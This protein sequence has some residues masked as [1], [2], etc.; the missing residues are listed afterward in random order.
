MALTQSVQAQK[1]KSSQ[2]FLKADTESTS[3]LT[4]SAGRWEPPWEDTHHHP[5]SRLQCGITEQVGANTDKYEDCPANCPYFAQNRKDTQHCT[6]L[7][8]PGAE[9]GRWNPNKPIP[10]SIKNTK[11]CRGPKVSFCKTPTLDGKD[12]CKVCMSGYRLH[13]DDGQCYFT[14]WT[15]I[16][17]VG[18]VFLVIFVLVTVWV[19]D[20]CC[21]R[22][23]INQESVTKAEAWRSRSKII[24]VDGGRRRTFATM[25]TNLCTKD[26]AGP[27]MLLH[28]NFQLFF[29]IWPLCCALVWVAL[30]CVHNELFIL[31]TR[32][33]G[34]PRHN[35]ILVAWGYETQQRLMWTKVLFLAVVYI[36][37]FI[38]FTLFFVTQL[39]KSQRMD[40]N[41][42]TMKDFAVELKGLPELPGSSKDVESEIQKAVETAMN[43][44]LTPGKKL[45]GVSVAWNYSDQQ[46]DIDMILRKELTYREVEWELSEKNPG[47]KKPSKQEVDKAVKVEM[48]KI[49]DSDPTVNMGGLHKW[50]YEK[51]KAV[52]GPDDDQEY[53]IKGMIESFKS[54]ESAFVVFDTAEDKDEALREFGPGGTK[55]EFDAT[56]YE[57]GK[58][59]LFMEEVTNEPANVNWH[60]FGDTDP[61]AMEFRFFKGFFKVYVPALLIWFFGF[62]VPYAWSLYNFNYDNGAELPG[63]YSI[64]FTIVVCGGNATMY[65]VCDVCCDIIGFRYKDTKQCTYMLM[66]LCACMINVFLDMVVTYYTA[67]KV[68]VGLDFRT[69]HGTRLAEIDVFTEQFETYAMQRSLGQNTYQYAWPSTFFLCFVLEPFVTILVPYQLGKVIIRTHSEIRGTTAEAYLQAFEFDLG[70]YADILLNV[71][72]G[73]LIFYFPGGYIWT[74]FFAMSFSHCFIY[75]F[76]HWRVINVI[77]TI[78]IVSVAVDWWAQVMMCGCC[79]V[80]MMCLVFKANCESYAGYC[81]QE[82][83]LVSTAGIAGTIHFIV[84]FLMLLYLVP[85][86]GLDLEDENEGMKFEAAAKNEART[87]FSVNPIHCLRSKYIHGDKTPCLIA[88]WGKEHLLEVNEKIGCFFKGEAAEVESFDVRKSF[89][90]LTRGLSKEEDDPKEASA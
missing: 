12:T 85:K 55:I 57:C 24:D 8:V 67:L 34:T 82:F 59:E 1:F 28:F 61:N 14:H 68:M 69:Y 44:K 15:A 78:K 32:K 64:I 9:C 18:L 76:D 89:S 35:C 36:G 90:G 2:S 43:K 58:T 31:G 11:T 54:S 3:S 60:N 50:M 25:G 37:S 7:C 75:C 88:A 27:G 87:W 73:I 21:I 41:E 30:A 33:F 6:F 39:R 72:L 16:I 38:S 20:M 80:I 29:I 77:P 23:A 56:K 47:K 84:H 62:Y 42:K 51:E 66:Y 70:R 86:L 74:L 65:V 45:V 26:V 83:E 81:L 4:K 40:A 49:S 71:F 17:S 22:E 79:A 10:D 63:Y 52:L 19:V 5:S 46:D 13:E 53:D 48:Q